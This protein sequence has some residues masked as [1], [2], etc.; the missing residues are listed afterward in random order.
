M[1]HTYILQYH[2]VASVDLL[3]MISLES[4]KFPGHHVGILPNGSPKNPANTGR[5]AH[6]SFTVYLVQSV[7]E[8]YA[9]K[10]ACNC[11]FKSLG[12]FIYIIAIFVPFTCIW[13]YICA[14]AYTYLDHRHSSMYTNMH[15]LKKT[16]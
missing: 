1:L 9:L 12:R 3:K 15:A 7:S 11:A 8:T 10:H 16:Q 4:K 2:H 5:G 14:K 6:A 13:S